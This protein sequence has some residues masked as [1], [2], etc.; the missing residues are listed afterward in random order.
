MLIFIQYIKTKTNPLACCVF[1]SKIPSRQTLWNPNRSL[2]S[3]GHPVEFPTVLLIIQSVRTRIKNHVNTYRHFLRWGG[4]VLR[5]CP[6]IA[7]I[8]DMTR[9][10]VLACF[11][12][13]D[14]ILNTLAH[15]HT[16]TQTCTNFVAKGC[17][18]FII[19]IIIF[20]EDFNAT[21]Q[22][23]T[24]WRT[25]RDTHTQTQPLEKIESLRVL[26]AASVLF[27]VIIDITWQ[28]WF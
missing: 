28:A 19:I 15:T 23:C 3:D 14:T 6:K 4:L 21:E 24:P 16:H 25:Y 2:E 11:V 22:L 20:C 5:L 1:H 18:L 17:F 27:V 26:T 13:T 8:S 12:S 9:S 10:S 7:P